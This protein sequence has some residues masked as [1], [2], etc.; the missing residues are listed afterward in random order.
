LAP[1]HVATIDIIKLVPPPPPPGGRPIGFAL[2]GGE[3]VE[4]GPIISSFS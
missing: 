1:K 2:R 4:R 3:I